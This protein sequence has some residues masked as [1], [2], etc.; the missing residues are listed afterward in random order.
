MIEAAAVALGLIL[1]HE[2]TDLDQLDVTEYGARADYRSLKAASVLE[3]SGTESLAELRRWH[4]E[5]VAQALAN[6]FGWNA[7]VAICA[8]SGQG[9]R[10]LFS[11]HMPGEA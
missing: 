4:R 2:L 5:K 11:K 7:Y 3:V 8:F 6:P 9:H 10:I 1:G